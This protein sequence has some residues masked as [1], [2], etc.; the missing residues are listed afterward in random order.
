MLA[1]CRSDVPE[2]GS[3]VD[4]SLFGAGEKRCVCGGGGGGGAVWCAWDKGE[5][6]LQVYEQSELCVGCFVD[7]RYSFY[8]NVWLENECAWD[9][10]KKKLQVYEQSELC[11]GC[12][13]DFR[14]S[15]YCNVWLEN[16]CCPKCI[17]HVAFYSLNS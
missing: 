1:V 6:K 10:G 13:V 12:F 8:C 9:K 7:F 16:E 14:Y 4:L 15:F 3:P 2:A 17:K 5:K 11:V